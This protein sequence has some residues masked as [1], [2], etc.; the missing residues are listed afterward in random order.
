MGLLI[1]LCYIFYNGCGVGANIWLAKWSTD[2]DEEA[3][4]MSLSTLVKLKLLC[5]MNF[6]VMDFH[7][8]LH[9]I[10]YRTFAYFYSQTNFMRL[11][12]QDLQNLIQQKLYTTQ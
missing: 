11:F 8:N 12:L 3:G 1:L 9:N 10:Q 7:E 6:H 2:E 5:S 4:N